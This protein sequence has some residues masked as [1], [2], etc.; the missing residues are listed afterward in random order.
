MNSPKL[1]NK[2]QIW[3]A[4][5]Y[6]TTPEDA[7]MIDCEDCA[8]SGRAGEDTTEHRA[9]ACET[10]KGFGVLYIDAASHAAL[11]AFRKPAASADKP[12]ASDCSVWCGERCD[13]ITG[14]A[15]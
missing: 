9:F 12:H 8:G 11:T 15:A 6:E 10:C 3:F 5:Q 7:V 1:P 4:H 13:C 2:P 14:K